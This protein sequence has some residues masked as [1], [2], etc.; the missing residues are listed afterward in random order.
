MDADK[1]RRRSRVKLAGHGWWGGVRWSVVGGRMAQKGANVSRLLP[2]TAEWWRASAGWV[3][4]C[5]AMEH[6]GHRPPRIQGIV[7]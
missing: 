6:A 3:R 5:V 4:C 7:H 1:T 2:L